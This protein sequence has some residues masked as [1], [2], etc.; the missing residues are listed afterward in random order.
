MQCIKWS[1]KLVVSILPRAQ[2]F[3]PESPTL[4]C[5]ERHVPPFREFTAQ[6]A[7]FRELPFYAAGSSSDR[8]LRKRK[9][10]LP[11]TSN[12]HILKRRPA[13]RIRH[14][15]PVLVRGPER[16]PRPLTRRTLH[17][18]RRRCPCTTAAA[19]VAGATCKVKLAL[20]G[21]RQSHCLR[22]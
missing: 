5:Q 4:G 6:Q 10:P 9:Q 20:P 8:S 1:S 12:L 13:I 7:T 2:C 11:T 21:L 15:P 16:G 19:A 17:H 18:P 3:Q 14:G 22:I